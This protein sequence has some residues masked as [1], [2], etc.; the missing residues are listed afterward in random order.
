MEIP[1][2]ALVVFVLLA[3]AA[4][5]FYLL[6]PLPGGKVSEATDPPLD[7]GRVLRAPPSPPWGLPLLG[8]LHLLG[9][10][11]HRALRSMAAAHGPVLLLRL[12]RVPAVLVSSAAA[13]DEV[14]RV[15]GLAFASRPRNAM[16]ERLLYGARDVAFAP[17]GEYWRQAR[18]VC[19]VHL[20]SARRVSAFRRAR[21]EEAAAMVGRVRV[22]ARATGGGAAAAFDLS[23]LLVAYANAVVSRA[24]FGDESARSLYGGAD[25]GR[26]LRKVFAD[27]TELLGMMPVRELLPWLGWV[28]T[29]RG[30]ERKARCTFEALDGVLDKVIDDHRR[31]RRRERGRRMDNA[32]HRDFVDV[33]L[34]VNETD[35]NEGG[36]QLDAIEIKAIIMDMFAAGT[37][38][39]STPMEWAMAELISHPCRMHKLQDEIR[40][41]VG[42]AGRITEDHMDRLP[43]LKAVLKETLRLHPPLPLLVP[44]EPQ[45]DTEIHG[46]HVAAR[47]Q[48]VINAWAI[49][50]DPA[51]WGEKAEE[52]MP[53][54]F[55]GSTVDYRGQSFEMVPFGGGRRGCPGVEFAMA[56][57]EMA[58]AS[59]LYHFNWEVAVTANG[60]L[61]DMSET[62]GL[63]VGL[64]FGLPLVAMPYFPLI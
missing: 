22:H 10:L 16:A 41:V 3:F 56:T 40:A 9:G 29:L 23:E 30:L 47:T 57:I 8:H 63:T 14:M 46:Y 15:R 26:E 19:V 37:D 60:R 43:Y 51:V 50:R 54:R 28:D 53:E 38:A 52:F 32:D 39:T 18:R 58:L 48:V 7:G 49:G 35:G 33:L 64:K 5:L 42:E 13:A 11:P 12:A 6:R 36:I 61:L 59:L 25:R 27:A 31:R 1:L 17:Y 24:A 34:D 62:N 20:L 4:S 55:L 21:E 2:G 44:R 45:V